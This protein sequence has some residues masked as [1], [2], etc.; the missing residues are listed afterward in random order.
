VDYKAEEPHQ[1]TVP[2]L[3]ACEEEEE[4]KEERQYKS[5]LDDKTGKTEVGRERKGA[6]TIRG[7][8]SAHSLATGPAHFLQSSQHHGEEREENAKGKVSETVLDDAEWETYD[9]R[10]LHLTCC[11]GEGEVRREGRGGNGWG[12]KGMGKGKKDGGRVSK[13]HT[14][15]A[16]DYNKP[17]GLTITPALSAKE[18]KCQYDYPEEK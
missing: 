15:G 5:R 7:H 10:S 4:G 11:V 14:P 12:R 8:K 3:D 17:F 9:G 13:R 18:G 16:G 2:A 6:R 1:T